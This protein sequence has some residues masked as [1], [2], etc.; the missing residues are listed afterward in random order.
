MYPEPTEMHTAKV[1]FP[2]GSPA[3]L[4]RLA[5]P[6]SLK[7]RKTSQRTSGFASHPLGW[8][9]F[10]SFAKAFYYFYAA[11]LIEQNKCQTCYKKVKEASKAA[12]K[13]LHGPKY[14]KVSIY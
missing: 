7:L 12:K 10:S 14:Y 6:P 13:E 9:A 2:P 3:I 5:L 1:L 8:F 11:S 4:L